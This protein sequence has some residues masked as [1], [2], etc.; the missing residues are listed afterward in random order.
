MQIFEILPHKN[1]IKPKK[2]STCLPGQSQAQFRVW[3]STTTTTY[4]F[5]NRSIVC[6]VQLR[7]PTLLHTYYFIVYDIYRKTSS[8]LVFFD[9]SELLVLSNYCAR[10]TP[11]EYCSGRLFNRLRYYLALLYISRIIFCNYFVFILSYRPCLMY[12]FWL[13]CCS[14][15][16]L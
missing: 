7:L 14:S 16:M 15:Y 9:C 13:P 2:N 12:V 1:S 3:I 5:V 10:V 11:F 4:Q 6:C 8:M